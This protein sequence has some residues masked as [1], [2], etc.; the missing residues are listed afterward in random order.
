MPGT[1]VKL[2]DKVRYRYKR[3]VNAVVPSS[4]GVPLFAEP[5][6]ILAPMEGVTDA[7]MR[8]FLTGLGGYDFCVTEFFRI[9][10]SI[11]YAETF[12]RHIPELVHGS[13]TMSGTPVVV[14]LLGGDPERV[15]ESARRAAEAGAF[16]IDL[17]FGCPAPT[18]NRNDGGASLLKDPPRLQ[19]I[20]AAV[21]AAVPRGV[22]VSAK[23][24]LGWSDIHEIHANADRVEAA[25]AAWI[26]IH[27]RTKEQ[28]YR[29]PV[30]WEP[31]A[32][33]RRRLSIPVVANGDVWS[34]D[35]WKRCRD[36]T[37]CEHF[38]LGRSALADPFL[39]LKIRGELRGQPQEFA[40]LRAP[41]AWRPLFE[42]FA[43]VCDPQSEHPNYPF[44]RIKQWLS[45]STPRGSDKP[46]WVEAFRRAN[47]LAEGL[48]QLAHSH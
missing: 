3:C 6:L 2:T 46:A 28:G 9:S 16:G 12:A 24:R 39:A 32:D 29:P 33:V 27:A 36:I 26:T 38:M 11:P 42:T 1:G 8:R 43:A 41:A 7:P 47:S 13:R 18:V 23:L 5:T 30:H 19:A 25:G 14:Q 22:S 20:I 35:D 15:A 40:D 17:N 48:Q 10:Q 4:R 21:R 44:R 45:L 34:V 31:I 37:G